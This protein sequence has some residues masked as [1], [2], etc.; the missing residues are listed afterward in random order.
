[1]KV[2][3]FIFIIL[4][5]SSSLHSKE[6]IA[7]VL[8]GGG[9]RGI[10][11]IGVLKA[12][13][14]MN[15][16]P[17]YIIGTSIGAIIGGM[18]S[19]GYST[20]QIDSIFRLEKFSS[21]F[22]LSNEV[23]RNE[24]FLY[25]KQLEQRNSVKLNFDNFEFEVPK[26]ISIGVKFDLIL[27]E[28]FWNAPLKPNND[29]DDLK[30][31]FR[32]VTTDLITGKSV[33]LKNGNIIDA[34]KASAS[35]PLRFPPVELDSMFLVDGG[36]K[37]NVPILIAEELDA[38]YIIA[39]N[40]SSELL[41]KE[42][43]QEPWSIAD[44]VVSILIKDRSDSLLNK[45]D[46]LIQP[47]I[48]NHSN[49]DFTNFDFLIQK[50]YEEAKIVLNSLNNNQKRN[51][52]EKIDFELISI[53]N[54]KSLIK[55]TEN[56]QNNEDDLNHYFTSYLKNKGYN[57]AKIKTIKFD[58]VSKSHRIYVDL[59]ILNKINI[60]GEQSKGLISREITFEVNQPLNLEKVLETYQ[61]IKNSGFFNNVNFDFEYN[62][63]GYT[64]NIKYEENPNQS[65]FLGININNERYTRLNSE[66]YQ[67]NILNNGGF[68]SLRLNLGARDTEFYLNLENPRIS[69]T[70]LNL[71]LTGYYNKNY[72]FT[73]SNSSSE[74]L[75][76]NEFARIVDNE[77][78]EERYGFKIRAG[79]LLWKFGTV[80]AEY[81]YEQ[82]RFNF[83][84]SEESGFYNLSTIKLESIIDTENSPFFPENGLFFNASIE[85]NFSADDNA[86]F[87]KSQVQFRKNVKINRFIITP[88][89][90]F[91]VADNLL[92]LPE[93]FSIGDQ[94]NFYGYRQ[95]DRRGR[96]YFNSNLEIKYISPFKLF[97]DT[98]FSVRYDLGSIWLTPE[99][100]KL[101]ELDN[102]IG[103]AI[104]VNSP[105][106]PVTVAAGRAFYF[107]SNP[108]SVILGPVLFYFSIGTKF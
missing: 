48:G 39:V 51:E 87:I 99:S 79:S 59:G 102:G 49:L 108:N 5:I 42:K 28:I 21:L 55:S 106:G 19:S 62:N 9:A 92:P 97:F 90:H 44:Q 101:A 46:F 11:Q 77:Y 83:I 15:I 80:Y 4:L 53:H 26:S 24:L 69:N 12:M 32:A 40:T 35:I 25:Q 20:S 41:E 86:R 60:I 64:L 85:S 14:E 7:L 104:H 45:A 27:K 78:Y 105:I 71:K 76:S 56:L 43:L 23:E 73:Y 17:N 63:P 84:R 37:N 89:V 72:I 75:E 18:Y 1:M 74:N 100:I 98:Y 8:S 38:K 3:I 2:Y 103:T 13:E 30:Y 68:A 10:S 81:R 96:Q 33:V 34:V 66:F 94:P 88:K 50:G 58:S 67:N 22:N 29:F 54:N 61:N 47:K 31:K 82:Q 6:E 65:I 16:K 95:F 36:I 70:P 107:I 52:L 57:F 93:Q 91:G